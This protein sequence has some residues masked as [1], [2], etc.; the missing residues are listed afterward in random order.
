MKDF[1][2]H[3]TALSITDSIC[4]EGSSLCRKMQLV[5]SVLFLSI[6]HRAY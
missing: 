5:K 1:L 3:K 4:R 2:G 6:E